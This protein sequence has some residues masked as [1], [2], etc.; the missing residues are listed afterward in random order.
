MPSD[1]NPEFTF[2]P[3]LN[4]RSLMIVKNSSVNSESKWDTLT[5]KQK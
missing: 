4:K 1:L 5:D 3:E 2:K